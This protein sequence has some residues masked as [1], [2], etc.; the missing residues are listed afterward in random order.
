MNNYEFMIIVN[1]SLTEEEITAK[2]GDVKT[3]LASKGANI[4]KEDV[5]GMKTLAYKINGKREAFYALYELELDG[6]VITE[7]SKEVNLDRDVWRY[8]FVKIED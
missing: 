8:M 5:W 1:P 7:F 6:K 4:T 3:L 2:L